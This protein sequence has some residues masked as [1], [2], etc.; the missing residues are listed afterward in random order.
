MSL[1]R[2]AVF[3][4]S[5]QAARGHARRELHEPVGETCLAELC[6]IGRRG[7]TLQE[8]NDRGVI[9]MWTQDPLECGMDLCEQT[10]DAVARR[11]H[12]SLPPP[13]KPRK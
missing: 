1:G 6:E 8:I 12:Q 7:M 5:Y 13:P 11:G 10:S 2:S 9:E 3:R 4:W